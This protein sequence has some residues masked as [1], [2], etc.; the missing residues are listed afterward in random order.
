MPTSTHY[1]SVKKI[2]D[3]LTA[4]GQSLDDDHLIILPIGAILL[5]ATFY[6]RLSWLDS[7]Y[8]FTDCTITPDAL[9]AVVD[10]MMMRLSELQ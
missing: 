3:Y 5:L 9:E 1:I 4:T 2:E 6:E 8:D 10:E 7:T